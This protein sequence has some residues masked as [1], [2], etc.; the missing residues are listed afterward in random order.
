MQV[1][2]E[3]ILERGA[4]FLQTPEILARMDS[5]TQSDIREG[6]K[7]FFL[8]DFFIRKKISGFAGTIDI[9]R[10]QDDRKVGVNSLDK[11]ALPSG[12]Y[13][14]L[15]NVGI[16]YALDT[17]APTTDIPAGVRYSS[18]EYLNTI[19]TKLINSE[20]NVLNGDKPVLKVRT[21]KFFANAYAEF[22]GEANDENGVSLPQP[23][24]IDYRKKVK[25][26]FEFA[27]DATAIPSG[28]HYVEIRLVGVYV[29]DRI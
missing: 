23:K 14:A 13:M 11:A 27:E 28:A 22:G 1:L 7:E 12:V 6:K 20:F 16:S 24:L 2:S 21:K 10:E 29:G 15:L 9:L 8:A 26:Q 3:T 4:R 18:A 25:L 5:Q 19:P 17:V